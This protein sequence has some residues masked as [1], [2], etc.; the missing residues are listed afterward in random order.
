MLFDVNLNCKLIQQIIL[1]NKMSETYDEFLALKI[2][3][4]DLYIIKIYNEY[5]TR[6]AIFFQHENTAVLF[7]NSVEWFNNYFVYFINSEEYRPWIDEYQIIR[8]DS[9]DDF[10]FKEQLMNDYNN[11]IY[12]DR[13]VTI[14]GKTQVENYLKFEIN[15]NFIDNY[16]YN[17]LDFEYFK[18][19][20]YDHGIYNE[21]F[22]EEV[23]LK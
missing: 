10:A 16:I 12:D 9:C 7:E 19:I 4:V 22:A 17:I 18:N 20:L 1:I 14:V 3:E 15:E 11:T 6:S 13:I 23:E 8:F 21:V 2:K 5:I